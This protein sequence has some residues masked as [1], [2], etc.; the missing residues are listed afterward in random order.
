MT[1]NTEKVSRKREKKPR[2]VRSTRSTKPSPDSKYTIAFT[3]S[4]RKDLQGIFDTDK[5]K[6]RK[7][8]EYFLS[9]P[10]PISFAKPLETSE[11]GD[12]RYYIGTG[13][14]QYRVTFDLIGRQITVYRIRDRRD[15]YKR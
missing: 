14:V 6:I 2:Q 8:L 3:R 11:V 10:N 7:K 5:R 13:R 1:R 12:F 9:A 4:A 15:V